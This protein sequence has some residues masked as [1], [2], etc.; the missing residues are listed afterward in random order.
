[1]IAV[2]AATECQEAGLPECVDRKYGPDHEEEGREIGPYP[3]Q[4][5]EPH[6]QEIVREVGGDRGQNTMPEQ[7]DSSSS[8]NPKHLSL[9]L[10][11]TFRKGRLA[12]LRHEELRLKKRCDLSFKIVDICLSHFAVFYSQRIPP[13]A[14]DQAGLQVRLASSPLGFHEILKS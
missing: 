5:K 6:A 8:A 10:F 3:G 7:N 11:R 14:D 2:Q 4:G 13:W 1:M 12:G 9:E